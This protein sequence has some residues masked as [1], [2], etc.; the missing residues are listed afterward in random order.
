MSGTAATAEAGVSSGTAIN[1]VNENMPKTDMGAAIFLAA[2]LTT[3][4]PAAARADGLS[5]VKE[6]E[7]DTS[8]P[9]DTQRL[10]IL[11]N[12]ETRGSDTA[13]TLIKMAR[14]KAKEGKDAEAIQWAALCQFE[15]ADQAAIKR[16]TASVLEYLKK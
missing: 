14:Q 3:S 4:M 7:N 8:S 6:C 13:A 11:P 15:S 16:D 9:E 2:L 10:S 12:G 1:R 5:A